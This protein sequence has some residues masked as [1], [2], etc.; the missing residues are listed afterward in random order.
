MAAMMPSSDLGNRLNRRVLPASFDVVDDP[1]Q[2]AF[3]GE[4]LIGGY[5]V[6]DQGVRSQPVTLVDG[7]IL[8]TLLMS[9]RPRNET[10]QSNGHGRAGAF[11]SASAQPGNLFVRA[12]GGLSAEVL[13]VELID[14]A[15]D[16]GLDYGLLNHRARRSRNHRDRPCEPVSIFL[17]MQGG[18]SQAQLTSPILAYK[19]YVE[20][21]RKEL[22]RGL[23]FRDVSVRSLRDIVASGEDQY[24]NN[25]FLEPG[26]SGLFRS[27]GAFIPSRFGGPGGQGIPAAVVAPSVLFEEL[28]IE[29]IGGPQQ[30][31]TL[32]GHPYF[33]QERP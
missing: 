3:A 26:G 11:G 20:D 4:A 31:P 21:G 12:E 27:L 15:R 13:K 2:A 28:E 17:L 24:V 22:V 25:R 9:R 6:D 1:T 18:A 30:A 10:P 7:G 16:I 23:G 32:M 19:V 5:A 8:R 29:R 14:L 33:R